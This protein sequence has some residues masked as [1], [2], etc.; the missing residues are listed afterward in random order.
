MKYKLLLLMTIFLVFLTRTS[1]AQITNLRV[2]GSATSFTITSGDTITWSYNVPIGATATVQVWYDVNGNGIID[3]STDVLWQFFTQ[4]DGDT[5]GGSGPP[6]M[7]GTANGTIFMK[8]PVGLAPGKY[9]MKFSQGGV[10]ATI[11][12]TVNKLASPAEIVSGKVTVPSGKSA[13]NIFVEIHPTR[14]NQGNFWD[15]I[16]DANGNYSIEMT[17]DTA[18]NPWT[19]NLV[20]NPYLPTISVPSDTSFTILQNNNVNGINFSIVAAAAQVNGS[21]EDENGN[22]LIKTSVDLNT[23]NSVL[24]NEYHGNTDTSGIFRIGILNQDITSNRQWQVDAS[25]R[26]GSDTTSTQLDAI[27]FIGT[28]SAGDSVFKRMI[29][30]NANSQIQ[31]TLK[32]DGAAPGFP[33]FVVAYNQD[34]TQSVASCDPSTGNFILPV[35]QKVFN[36]Q[37]FPINLGPHYSYTGVMAHPGNTGIV[38]DLTT[39]AVKQNKVTAPFEFSLHQNYPNPFNPTTTITYDVSK[40]AYVK[41]EVFNILGE[42]VATL[43]NETKAPG[44]YHVTFDGT[45]FSSGVYLYR[46]LA[47]DFVS[48][49]KLILVK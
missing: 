34:S 26:N 31:G 41:I 35:T 22:P 42:K 17:A 23:T 39:T 5:I 15:G 27:A 12:G 37:V 38:V 32:I 49:K 13:A 4:T 20:N 24:T 19:A 29:I 1:S 21:V 11:T 33:V 30:Y 8:S 16:T 40:S 44:E 25:P 10:T 48:V 43:V 9:V 14:H 47:G 3:P 2:N 46:M 18:G 45:K 6:D 28:I 36:Y 7:D